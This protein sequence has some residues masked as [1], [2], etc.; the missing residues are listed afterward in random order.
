VDALVESGDIYYPPLQPGTAE[1]WGND[2]RVL[3]TE[4]SQ[5]N[6]PEPIL[7]SPFTV[8]VASGVTDPATT[9]AFG[10]GL[11]E[12]RAGDL[13]Q[14][15]IQAKDGFGNNRM[16]GQALDRFLVLPFLP[17]EDFSSAADDR[18]AVEASVEQHQ[19]GTYAVAFTPTLSGTYTVPVLA[20]DRAEVQLVDVTVT[21]HQPDH[22]QRYFQL[23][24]PSLG[25]QTPPL[26]WNV[27]VEDLQDALSTWG[28]GDGS[29]SVTRWSEPRDVLQFSYRITFEGYAGDLPLLEAISGRGVNA[30]A[31][32]VQDGTCRHIKTSAQPLVPETQ[33]LRVA[34]RGHQ[35]RV[36]EWNATAGEVQDALEALLPVG[37]VQVTQNTTK[38]RF[39]GS[40]YLLVFDPEAGCDHQHA[41][42]YGD[43]PALSSTWSFST[44]NASVQVYASG[45][46]S[47]DGLGTTDGLSPFAATVQSAPVAAPFVTAVD[48]PGVHMRQGLHTGRYN[49]TA[50]FTIESRDR[51]GNRVTDG[52]LKEIQVLTTYCVGSCHLGGSFILSYRG[53]E[54][55]LD[56][57]VGLSE[58]ESTLESMGQVGAV[59]VTT[60]SVTSPVAAGGI[61]AAVVQTDAQITP[62][63]DA[64]AYLEVGDW[65]RLGSMDGDVYTIVDMAT[66][67]PYTITLDHPY[68]A[69]SGTNTSMFRQGSKGSVRG[70]QYI[71]QFDSSVG[72]LPALVV[73]GSA[74]TSGSGGGNTTVAEV[75]ACDWNR[76]QTIVLSAMSPIN[77]SFYLEYQGKRTADLPYDVNASD[78]AEA[79]LALPDLYNVGIEGPFVG[80]YGGRSW[81][82]L[83]T[84][85]A[86]GTPAELYAE[87]HLLTGDQVGISVHNACP[88]DGRG[89]FPGNCTAGGG[90]VADTADPRAHAVGCEASSVAGRPGSD[91]FLELTG[92]ERVPG[93]TVHGVDGLYVASYPTPRAGEFSLRVAE[94]QCCGLSAAIFNNRWLMG[95]PAVTRVDPRVDFTW[96]AADLLT[97]TGKDFISIRWTGYLQPAFDEDYTFVLHAND[98][99]RLFLDDE[100]LL[101][102]FE[103]EVEDGPGEEPEYRVHE[104]STGEALAAD[105]LHRVRIEFRESTGAAVARLLWRS[106]SQPLE[107]VPTHR[108]FHS[109]VDIQ[110]SPWKVAPVPIAPLAPEDLQLQVAAWDSLQATWLAPMDDGGADVS[111]F[112]VEWWSAEDG[113]YGAKEVQTIKMPSTVDE[114][115]WYLTSPGGESHFAAIPW[116]AAPETVEAA[117]EAFPD[118]GDV[119]VGLVLGTAYGT[120]DYRI[121]FETDLGNVAPLSVATGTLSTSDTTGAVAIVVCSDG[122]ATVLCARN[123]STAGN[124]TVLGY[125]TAAVR[126]EDGRY[127]LT[128][129]DLR[130]AS[131]TSE[132]FSVRVAARNAGTAGFGVAS[133]PATRKPMDVAAAPAAAELHLVPG[134]PSAL[135]VFWTDVVSDRGSAVDAFLVE[136]DTVDSFDTRSE[137]VAEGQTSQALGHALYAPGSYSSQ[138]LGNT[139]GVGWYE[140][141]IQGLDP[142]LSYHVR[143]RA[144][145][146]VGLGDLRLPT[147]RQL[148]PRSSPEPLAT[149][150]VTLSTIPASASVTVAESSRSLLVE[151]GASEDDRGAPVEDYL[152]EW[153]LA[154]E[155]PRHEVQVVRLHGARGTRGTFVLDY[156]GARTSPL[157]HDVGE[158]DLELALEALPQVRDVQVTRTTTTSNSNGTTLGHEWAV[159]FLTEAPTVHGQRL[160]LDTSGVRGVSVE[161]A[162]GFDLT[163]G[164][165]GY[166]GTV[167]LNVTQRRRRVEVL[168]GQAAALAP[169]QH[170]RI[171]G[172]IYLIATV[173]AGNTSVVLDRN[174][175]GTGTSGRVSGC[176]FGTAVPGSLPGSLRSSSVLPF[177]AGRVSKGSYTL[178]DL[179]VGVPYAMRVSPRNE[180][181]YA[182]PTVSTPVALAPPRQKP[183]VPRDVTL[184]QDSDSSL[185]LLFRGPESDGGV[186]VT[187]YRIEWDPSPHFNSGDDGLV[188]GSYHKVLAGGGA[189]TAACGETSPCE[190]VISGLTRGT[191]F[192]VR[193]FAYNA[194]GYSVAGA[195]SSPRAATPC[196]FASPPGDVLVLPTSS[197]SLRVEFPSSSDDGGCRVTHYKV[198]W[199][200]AGGLGYSAGATS[201][202]SLLYAPDGVQ[203]V[204]V[205]AARND[206]GGSFRI[207]FQHFASAPIAAG[208]A[209]S[210]DVQRA[211]EG[212]PTM[213]KVRVSR[214]ELSYGHA[215]SVTFVGQ[216]GFADA[217]TLSV[218]TNSSDLP[219]EFQG[220]AVGGDLVGTN[221]TVAV[222]NIVDGGRG[223]EQQLL[224]I[225]VEAGA[226]R[227]TFRLVWQGTASQ[228]LA[229]NASASDVEAALAALGTGRVRV[230]RQVQSQQ[231][232]GG[233]ESSVHWVVE[234]Q[235]AGDEAGL[236]A[237][238]ATDLTSSNYS[239]A[240]LANVTTAAVGD[241]PTFD[242]NLKGEWVV[243]TTQNVTARDGELLYWVDLQELQAREAYNVRVSA[244]NGFGNAYGSAQYSAPPPKHGLARLY[245]GS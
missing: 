115:A 234:F 48:Q 185:R 19:D 171:D 87:G 181:G 175:E 107:L 241:T 179:H 36:L 242:S 73:D 203:V 37:T 163:P 117:L 217:A 243:P 13:S 7:G 233:D 109:T 89:S 122:N 74:L 41:M 84:S 32:A 111:E 224:R 103:E 138:R 60:H 42:T 226:L 92:A 51:F 79:L 63:A 169:G 237:V 200:A 198:E 225:E 209:S 168:G 119:S 29:V 21:D 193:V 204:A 85:V 178:S 114:G 144:R 120:R 104:A 215:Y 132:G 174:F 83:L 46:P 205:S 213:G 184:L 70:Y 228:P 126:Q 154:D 52:P 43:L 76:R 55:G 227:G 188:L 159:T 232:L 158:D 196:T 50:S 173:G 68:Q 67:S 56:A 99:V 127:S 240:V 220:T 176:T 93:I 166:A 218:S 96:A 82:V 145:N 3:V 71:I 34:F 94:A 143:I 162:V 98:G 59:T 33:A 223:L 106:A 156:A 167:V 164:L 197:S 153:W 208:G 31:T 236:L 112:K 20:A 207:G 124:A 101:D 121:T 139:S 229:W 244:F 212:I 222:R 219:L 170:I 180:Q 165:P 134:S 131:S 61:T 27:E 151:F 47:P 24:M 113:G 157:D 133:A 245:L 187:R 146:A 57:G 35:T 116:D 72:D 183:D 136:W 199:D 62:S 95:E 5:G 18:T 91:F 140:H 190:Y 189:G 2:A 239:A 123:D 9:I 152:V 128:I 8:H 44:S 38:G 214:S 81:T 12:G 15:T 137:N 118:V 78:L 53:V 172:E 210:R 194:M 221:A 161:A 160:R 1:L 25:L 182:V 148:A 141:L 97:E 45:L 14:F 10:R 26:A 64:S 11:V 192:Y 177:D 129:E 195:E 22:A 191:P 230:A 235:D 155:P 108:L 130:Q 110:G 238:D 16:T 30:T 88:V 206:L 147:P 23:A 86:T 39:Y 90:S 135:R 58:L 186:A 216:G 80:A 231:G 17:F 100:L 142:G 149:G 28:I 49:S 211:L 4:V 69:A 150:A 102:A 201:R 65:L 202:D 6:A 54:V 66:R 77:G 40:E 125:S 105:Q 75:T